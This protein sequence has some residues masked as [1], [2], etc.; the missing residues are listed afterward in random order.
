VDELILAAPGDPATPTGGYV[1]DAHILAELRS[2]GRE[3]SALRLPDDFPEA[4]QGSIDEAL[5]LLGEPPPSATLIVDGLAYGVLPAERL[6]ALD[7]PLVALVHHPLA[8]ESGLDPER[9]ARLEAAERAALAVAAAVVT[10][11]DRTA[12]MLATRFGVERARLHVARPGVDEAPRAAGSGEGAPVILTVATVTPRKNHLALA[13]AL[14]GLQDLDWRWRIVGSLDR[15]P[16]CAAALRR[17]IAEAGLA[18]RVEFAGEVGA[19][20][21]ATSYASADLFALVSLYEGYGMAYAEALAH[22]LPTIAGASA[23][24]VPEAAG[25]V[26]DPLDAAG[27]KKELRRLIGDPEARRRAA[28]R[29]WAEAERLPRWP[30]A[31]G[32]FERVAAALSGK[33]A[34]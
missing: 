23:G 9:A 11:S 3:A 13:G 18:D 17:A 21:L 10:T 29:A 5:R 1:Y 28:D 7:R 30:A 26:V 20:A 16:A 4:S 33:A 25:A 14:A 12:E 24:F 6:A 34:A 8:L 2:R 22:G 32:I 19:A 15:D 31:A 27:L